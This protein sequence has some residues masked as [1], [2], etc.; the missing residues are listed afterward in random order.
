MAGLPTVKLTSQA[1][2]PCVTSSSSEQDQRCNSECG[3]QRLNPRMN[4]HQARQSIRESTKQSIN[5][6]NYN[7]DR[8][9]S[10]SRSSRGRQSRARVHRAKEA[11]DGLHK[12]SGARKL[13]WGG[14]ST[15]IDLGRLA[16]RPEQHIIMSDR[17]MT[18][19]RSYSQGRQATTSGKHARSIPGPPRCTLGERVI[20]VARLR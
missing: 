9:S 19:G 11:E 13:E 3:V 16:Q 20:K 1:P 17:R 12:A 6:T 14:G 4:H 10:R 18:T 2:P 8:P 5:Q 7:I 15:R